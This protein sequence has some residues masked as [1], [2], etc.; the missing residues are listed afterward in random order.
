VIEVRLNRRGG[1]WAESSVEC[2]SH[3]IL[4]WRVSVGAFWRHFH[5]RL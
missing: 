4:P 3:E 2:G 5:E 1:L